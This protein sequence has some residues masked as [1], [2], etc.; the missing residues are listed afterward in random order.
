MSDHFLIR[1]ALTTP[2][3]LSHQTTLDGILAGLILQETGDMN[4]ALSALPLAK[5]AGVWCGSCIFLQSPVQTNEIVMGPKVR[6]LETV[7]GDAR[8]ERGHEFRNRQTYVRAFSTP[9][10]YF[11]GEGDLAEVKRLVSGMTGI[12]KKR[13]AG[14]GQVNISSS[15][16]IDLDAPREQGAL[17]LSDGTPSRPIPMSVW[18]E[19]KSQAPVMRAFVRFEPPYNVTEPVECALPTRQHIDVSSVQSLMM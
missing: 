17:M 5:Q 7:G 19:L 16:F 18:S 4:K 9:S 6:Q 11:M 15:D 2:V 12:G 1:L 8:P 14:Y 10:A 13:S 3:I